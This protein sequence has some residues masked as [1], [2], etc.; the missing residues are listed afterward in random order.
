MAVPA[1]TKE[2]SY[3]VWREHG[4]NLSET[5]RVLNGELG[6]VISRQ[7]LHAWKAEYDWENRA[8]RAEAETKRLEKDSTGDSLLSFSI[9][10]K[11]K[12]EAYFESLPVGKIDNNAVYAY[13][14]ILKTIL[15]IREKADA[16]LPSQGTAQATEGNEQRTIGTPQDA[17]C[18]LED[19]VERRL[20]IMLSQPDSVTMKAVQEMEKAL[21]LIGKLKLQYKAADDVSQKKNVDPETLK[22]IREEVYGII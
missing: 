11:Q 19:A 10:Q 6:Y 9:K 22:K 12:Y 14:S 7:S 15:D 18:A 2:L 16:V 3:K 1:E 5:E 20:N 8:A 4:Q 13:N 21:A 17:V